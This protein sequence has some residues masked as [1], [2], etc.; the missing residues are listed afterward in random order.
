MNTPP[1]GTVTFLFTDIEGSTRLAQDFRD[2]HHELIEKHHAILGDSVKDC[3]GH[4]F[5][6]V[7]DAFC[8]SFL[9]AEDAVR[10]AV[11]IQRKLGEEDWGNAAMKVR[12]GIHSGNAEW[13]GHD[14]MGYLTLV[15]TNRVMSAAHGG[16]VIVSGSVASQLTLDCEAEICVGRGGESESR[17]AFRD[18]GERRLKDLIEPL[19]IYQLTGEGLDSEF[20]PLKTLD[21]R[22][23]NLPVQLSS[24]VGREKELSE[25][26]ELITGS[27]LVTLVGPGGTG[28]TRLVLQAAAELIDNFAHGVWFI[29]LAALSDSSMLEE[30]MLKA[31]EIEDD[32]SRNPLQ[33]LA[34][35]LKGKELL[36]ILDNC[37]HIVEAC[38]RIAEHILS[39]TAKVRI[40]ATSRE[41]LRCNGEITCKVSSLTYPEPGSGIS[42]EKLTEYSSVRLFIERA[43]SVNQNFRINKGNSEALARICSQLDGIPL[44]IELAAARSR[45][46]NLN[47]ISKRLNDRFSLLTGGRRN[48]L[49]RQKTLRATIDWSHDLLA[50]KEKVLWRR[51]SVFT[52]GWSLE[53]A[54]TVCEG[55]GLENQ[56]ILDISEQLVEK[57]IISFSDLSGR[58]GMLETMRQYGREKMQEADETDIISGKLLSYFLEFCEKGVSDY[59]GPRSGERM[60]IV[61]SDYPNIQTALRWAV[62]SNR[63]AEGNRLACTLGKFWEAR[64]YLVEGSSWMQKLLDP[65]FGLPAI[66]RA[67]SLKLSAILS[68]V[69][70]QADKAV[71]ELEEAKI[72]F[73]ECDDKQ[74]LAQVL[75]ILGL[76]KFDT[77]HYDV[78]KEY[79][80]ESL[81]LKR[82]SGVPISICSSLNSLGLLANHLGRY[83]E[84]LSYYDE[85][86][87]IAEKLSDHNYLSI[88]YNNIAEA[89]DHMGDSVKAEEYFGKGLEIDRKLGNK[90]ALCISLI[91]I[92]TVLLRK[93][94][95][96]EAL[97]S[98][99]EA[100]K[101]AQETGFKLGE[102]YSVSNLG[103]IC[104]HMKEYEKSEQYF[105]K[106][107][108]EFLDV[109]DFKNLQTSLSG[110]AEIMYVKGEYKKSCRLI[111]LLTAESEQSGV[112][113]EPRTEQFFK[114]LNEK[115]TD[116]IGAQEAEIEF[117]TGKS[118][119][120]VNMKT[121]ALGEEK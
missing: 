60:N 79:L 6:I 5:K 84:A 105:K 90:N 77:G 59:T 110:L 68:S 75:N 82:E 100:L 92:S 28:K 104:L 53:A 61:E 119:G 54:E 113:L 101:L 87:A 121:L 7:G 106:I 31:L 41:S 50:E 45:L 9:K 46:L 25:L 62:E 117:N 26:R 33:K 89:S 36:L 18:L 81:L 114:D 102:V 4:V 93:Q 69:L 72:L 57:S 58:F 64:G 39:G 49:P 1:S 109:A 112:A 38:S 48:V 52:G 56:E 99:T 19:R 10:A 35:F 2:I 96:S 97:A 3:G 23:N 37:E 63:L 115:L 16:Q 116:A 67:N 76:A 120:F 12:M 73:K 51:L 98:T 85:A 86:L 95:F 30:S 71:A 74:G 91:N 78:A 83:E 43:L 8:C 44:A 47:D 21:A 13:N 29:D 94:E 17:V 32:S 27:R 88:L 24:F 14:Y 11:T 66:L 107:I 80:E 15:R 111:G 42:P 118:L 20:P 65:S 34:D 55:S 70:G 40:F 22:P 103:S 108:N